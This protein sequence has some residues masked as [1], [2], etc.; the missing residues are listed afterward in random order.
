M[1]AAAF[2]VCSATAAAGLAVAFEVG[3]V[4]EKRMSG[5]SKLAMPF[6]G[7]DW[8]GENAKMAAYVFVGLFFCELIFVP[9]ALNP[10][11]YLT[12]ENTTFSNLLA[13]FV[14]GL[15]S[16]LL[17]LG[18]GGV[19][20]SFQA[21]QL[22]RVA[23]DRERD[24]LEAL[25]DSADQELEEERQILTKQKRI[26][27][28]SAAAVAG[29]WK[30]L[31]IAREEDLH[32]SQ[33][34]SENDKIWSQKIAKEFDK[35]VMHVVD[36]ATDKRWREIEDQDLTL[37]AMRLRNKEKQKR[38]IEER[39]IRAERANSEKETLKT[40]TSN[41]LKI[42]DEIK[43]L[44]ANIEK[45]KD[46]N[47]QKEE[48][49]IR[50]L[51]EREE[52]LTQKEKTLQESHL[53]Q[54]EELRKQAESLKSKE[55]EFESG[56]EHKRLKELE[57]KMESSKLVV[58]RFNEEVMKKEKQKLEEFRQR[59]EELKKKEEELKKRA[60]WTIPAVA[61]VPDD[62]KSVSMRLLTVVQDIESVQD[63][64]LPKIGENV[65]LLDDKP[66]DEVSIPPVAD[67]KKSGESPRPSDASLMNEL[68][69]IIQKAYASPATNTKQESGVA[70]SSKS[71]FDDESIASQEDLPKPE[72][73]NDG[74][75]SD[76]LSHQIQRDIAALDK[77]DSWNITIGEQEEKPAPT[78]LTPL[79]M[80]IQRRIK[81]NLQKNNY[82]GGYFGSDNKNV[83]DSMSYTSN[84]I[85]SQMTFKDVQSRLNSA[86]QDAVT[87]I[88]AMS[89]LSD[90]DY[91]VWDKDEQENTASPK[92]GRKKNRG[93]TSSRSKN[94]K[95]SK[96]S[97]VL[98]EE[99]AVEVIAWNDR[100][101]Y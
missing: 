76:S 63:A 5:S 36:N 27:F 2:V 26:N 64:S 82:F 75:D 87:I 91:G 74:S 4:A 94:T 8:K 25:R 48:E 21:L 61:K 12:S 16:F 69:D 6:E 1:S 39:A 40:E 92:Q 98:S 86:K 13:L 20:D 43:G 93:K 31:H 9:K 54:L 57:E 72:E 11:S 67:E 88:S 95:N 77:K 23:I 15:W 30:K 46:E 83:D 10:F 41:L 85:A 49:K 51:K 59:E 3:R 38:L 52:M 34:R 79:Q 65:I 53:K 55:D 18:F 66:E 78:P 73:R 70:D 32:R 71:L 89:A 97:Y 62:E 29:E 28:A 14:F 99:A 56:E 17:A 90:P 35:K 37:E 100:H 68:E 81:N 42:T 101:Q 44:K 47:K 19:A 58:A 80:R 45:L 84:T 50:E 24:A 7:F 60:A 22:E 96:K 33:E